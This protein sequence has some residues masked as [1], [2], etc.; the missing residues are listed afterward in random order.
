MEIL[1]LQSKLKFMGQFLAMGTI[2]R[3]ELFVKSRIKNFENTML[4]WGS[5]LGKLLKFRYSYGTMNYEYYKVGDVN[6]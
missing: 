4:L 3:S 6:E 1:T 5:L 2:P